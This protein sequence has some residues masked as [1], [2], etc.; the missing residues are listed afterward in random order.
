MEGV[1]DHPTSEVHD[2]A[3]ISMYEITFIQPNVWEE[4]RQKEN[5]PEK[6][7]RVTNFL[8]L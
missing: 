1:Q 7:V 3:C 5:T 6:N 4:C 2:E 8:L